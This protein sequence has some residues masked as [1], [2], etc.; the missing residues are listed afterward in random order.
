MTRPLAILLL[1]I[2]LSALSAHSQ[3]KG[4]NNDPNLPPYGQVDKADLELKQCDF[5]DKAEAMVLLEDGQLEYVYNRGMI[6]YK[7]VRI[8]ILNNKGRD[9][10]N[11]HLRYRSERNLQ[12]INGLEAQTYNLDAAGNVIVS[13]LDKKTVYDQKV[14]KKFSEKVFSFPEVKVGSIIE[15]K[16]KHENIG[17]VDWYFQRDIPVRYS[18]FVIDF[19]NEIEVSAVPYCT[20]NYNHDEDDQATRYVKSYSMSKVPGFRD[21]PY[22]LNDEFY[23]DRLITKV[24]AYNFNG[25]RES[26]IANWVQVIKYLMEDEDFGVQLKRNI[27]R[28][29][30]LDA[31][32]KKTSSPYQRMKTIYHYVQ[33]NMQWNEYYGIWA[34]DGVRSAWKDKKGTVGEINLILVNLLKDADLNAHAVLASTHDNGV[35]NSIDAGTYEE[36]GF[37]QFDKVLAY[38]EIGDEVYVLDASEKDTPVELFPPDV[39]GTEGLLIEKIDTYEWGWKTLWKQSLSSR[40]FL[41]IV[42]IIDDSGNLNAQANISSD[43]YARLARLPHARKGKDEF[44]QKVVVPGNPTLK[45]EELTFENLDADSLPLIQHIKFSQP[46]SSSGDYKYFSINT[47]SGLELNPFIADTRISD[48]FFGYNQSFLVSG[49]YTLPDGYEMETTPKNVRMI[50]PDTSISVS[51]LSQISGN[52]VMIRFTLDFKK[53]VYP[54]SQYEDLQAFYKVLFDILNEQFVIRKKK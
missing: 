53:P 41:Q 9:R 48:V 27:P 15:Y 2:L 24:T 10:A 13:K 54:V 4:K 52:T 21:E 42:G 43:G 50:M 19:P 17:L 1:C 11:I 23:M 40:N 3:K 38:V 46:L 33:K 5:D 20:H 47:L 49:T 51:R 39:V 18:H 44:T 35:V 45:V 36:P 8:K 37:L 29:D 7:R 28:T 32:L 6:Y 30:D 14:N 31:A 16:Y 22:L 34:S 26:R 12:E 25:R